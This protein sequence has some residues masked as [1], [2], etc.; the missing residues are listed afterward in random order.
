M[1][2]ERNDLLIKQS[3]EIQLRLFG[4]VFDLYI[5]SKSAYFQRYQ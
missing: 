5:A 4:T 1:L 3:V 2:A